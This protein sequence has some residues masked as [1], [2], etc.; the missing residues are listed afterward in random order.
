M[1]DASFHEVQ[2][3]VGI[4]Y[5]AVGG[6]GFHTTVLTLVSG[7]EQRNMDW[8]RARA[9][10]DVAQGLKTQAE[11][12]T[13]IRFFMSRRG[14]AFGFRFKDWSDYQVPNWRRVPGDIEA[15]PVMFTTDGVTR[16]FQI[17]KNYGDLVGNYLRNIR[18]PVPGT[19]Q[20]TAN[21]VASSNFTVDL[22][23]G[24][25]TLGSAIYSTTGVA[26]ALSCEFDVPVRFDTDDMKVSLQ[27]YNNLSWGSIT[28]IE[29]RTA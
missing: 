14:K 19:V 9:T 12:N 27:D 5:G 2:F 10:Y 15:L 29:V 22:T 4:S 8:S 28:L 6:P 23:T 24:I 7:Y 20:L 18:K 25:V 17:V 21:G 1:A 16:T 3:P 11:L 13:L 26:V